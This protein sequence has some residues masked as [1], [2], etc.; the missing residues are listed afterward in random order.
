MTTT[1]IMKR[2]CQVWRTH[3][4]QDAMLSAVM[5]APHYLDMIRVNPG[6]GSWFIVNRP[7]KEG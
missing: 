3:R 1:D 2:L 5:C 4:P 7:K 6:P